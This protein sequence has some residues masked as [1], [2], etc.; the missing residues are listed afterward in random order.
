MLQR[1]TRRLHSISMISQKNPIRTTIMRNRSN[2]STFEIKYAET[3]FSLFL[4]LF[5]FQVLVAAVRMLFFCY[6]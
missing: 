2:S 4:L 6:Q 1:P 3:S 5:L